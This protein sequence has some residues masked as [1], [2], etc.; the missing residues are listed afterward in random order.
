MAAAT[1]GLQAPADS[2]I[3]K[4]CETVIDP[5]A[6]IS[7]STHIHPTVRIGP[8]CH[9]GENVSIGPG[10]HLVSH[11]SVTGPTVIGAGNVIHPFVS[12]GGPAQ[13]L[14]HLE[15]TAGKLLIG[16][17]NHIRENVTISRGTPEGGGVT[18]VESDCLVMTGVHI[19]HDATVRSH[20]VIVSGAQI[21]GHATIGSHARISALA[22]IVQFVR[23]GQYSYTTAGAIVDRDVIPFGISSGNPAGIRGINLVGLRRAGFPRSSINSLTNAWRLLSHDDRPYSE[24]RAAILEEC[25]GA[26]EVGLLMDFID[27]SRREGAGVRFR[28]ARGLPTSRKAVNGGAADPH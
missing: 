19:G 28:D 7:A 2:R 8:Y 1:P 26:T 22:G 6:L 23:V 27:T 24:L 5:T 13:H 14:D 25:E 20:V 17:N 15:D 9:I 12:L 21:G 4:G 3:R 10:T 16:D 11:V 18:A